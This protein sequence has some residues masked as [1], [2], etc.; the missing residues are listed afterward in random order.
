MYPLEA[1][2]PISFSLSSCNELQSQGGP[3]RGIP[4]ALTSMKRIDGEQLLIPI[5]F[6]SWEIS[7]FIHL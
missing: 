4:F 6:L 5:E 2:T 7:E 1:S 3:A